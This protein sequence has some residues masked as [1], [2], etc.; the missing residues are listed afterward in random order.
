MDKLQP[1][2]FSNADRPEFLAHVIVHGVLQR[3]DLRT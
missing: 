2:G 1:I 3:F